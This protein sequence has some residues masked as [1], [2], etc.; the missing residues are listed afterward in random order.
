MRWNQ[1]DVPSHSILFYDERE[2]NDRSLILN[3]KTK[4]FRK[5]K[6][7]F[8]RVRLVYMLY[9]LYIPGTYLLYIHEVIL[10]IISPKKKRLWVLFL[11][12]PLTESRRGE[13]KKGKVRAKKKKKKKKEI[14]SIF[15]LPTLGRWLFSFF[16]FFKKDVL[17]HH[18]YLR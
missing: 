1:I 15:Y 8:L 18:Y 2:M 5:K 16:F 4:K 13:E 7:R 12:S 11:F 14:R 10:S 9:I 3:L 6:K 17:V